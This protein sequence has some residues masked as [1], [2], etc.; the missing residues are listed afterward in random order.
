MGPD[1]RHADQTRRRRRHAILK[2]ATDLTMYGVFVAQNPEPSAM[3]L[4]QVDA[5][6]YAR[7]EFTVIDWTVKVVTIEITSIKPAVLWGEKSN[8]SMVR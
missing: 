1:H 8:G 5:L 4:F 2:E 6:V 7:Q 3:F